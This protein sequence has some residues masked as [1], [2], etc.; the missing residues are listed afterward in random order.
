MGVGL[1]GS[2]YWQ[3]GNP[4]TDMGSSP[5]G[6]S[7]LEQSPST[8]F[9]RYGVGI[10][11]PDNQSAFSRWFKQQYPSVQTG[12][13]AYTVSNPLTANITDYLNS[14]GGF[15]DWYRQ[16]Q[17]LAP[18]LRGEDAGSRGG[19]PVRWVGR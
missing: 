16:F 9:Y 10:G 14:L 17:S 6:Q 7:M 5:W 15:N 4:A 12:Y 13:Q 11:V 3:P 2:F 19:G 8:A 18:Q 1:G